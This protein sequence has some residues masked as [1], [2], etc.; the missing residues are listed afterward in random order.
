M[1]YNL[2]PGVSENDIPG[3]RPEDI[4]WDDLVDWLGT[5]NLTPREIRKRLEVYDQLL[6]SARLAQL[7]FLKAVGGRVETADV[8]SADKQISD[9]ILKA[10]EE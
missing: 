5:L 9:A 8:L 7:V 3:N 4:A 10:E 1:S 6:G 2:P